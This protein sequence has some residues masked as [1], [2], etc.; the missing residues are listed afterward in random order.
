MKCIIT[1]EIACA[2]LCAMLT[3]IFVPQLY[4]Q[5]DIP[6]EV[7]KSA[8]QGLIMYRNIVSQPVTIRLFF[9]SSLIGRNHN[10]L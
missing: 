7:Y 10:S 8:E 6:S 1:K 5:Q 3:F 9:Y 4:P 2:F